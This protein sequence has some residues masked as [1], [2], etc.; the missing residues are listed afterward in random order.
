MVPQHD[1]DEGHLEVLAAGGQA[2]QPVEDRGILGEVTRPPAE[3]KQSLEAA[4]Q[5]PVVARDAPRR[6]ISLVEHGGHVL[7]RETRGLHGVVDSLPGQRIDQSGRLAHQQDSVAG[8]GGLGK[9]HSDGIAP[10]GIAWPGARRQRARGPAPDEA[11]E[12]RPGG[13]GAAVSPAGS[14]NE[15]HPNVGHCVRERENP[16]IPRQRH[17]VEPDLNPVREIGRAPKVPARGEDHRRRLWQKAQAS[18]KAR[19]GAG[20]QDGDAGFDRHRSPLALALHDDAVAGRFDAGDEDPPGEPGPAPQRAFADRVVERDPRDDQHGRREAVLRRNR[21][22]RRGP[23]GGEDLDAADTA[24]HREEA[25][26]HAHVPERADGPWR[27][28]VPADLVAGKLGLVEEEDVEAAPGQVVRGR[29]SPRAGAD[30]RHVVVFGVVDLIHLRR[31]LRRESRA[32]LG[33][34]FLRFLR[35]NACG[36]QDRG[37]PAGR[38]GISRTAGTGFE[39]LTGCCPPCPIPGPAPAGARRCRTP[40]TEPTP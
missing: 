11:I 39:T 36:V 12:C 13:E 28:A 24:S 3:D 6:Q 1:V 15:P 5:Q 23:I 18:K 40:W 4:A 32:A 10:H 19:G 16:A 8:G 38:P 34:R 29:G 22:R 9:V 7:R 27:Q 2:H 30:N 26:Q 31:G 33:G 14:G 21:R 20:C 37:A 17:T 35:V 25:V